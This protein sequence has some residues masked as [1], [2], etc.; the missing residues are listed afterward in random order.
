ML[1]TTILLE[2]LILKRLEISD[3]ELDRFDISDDYVE[4]AKKSK[5]SKAKNHL[6]SKN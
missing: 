2:R 3:D 5:K 6:S 1:I 4:Y